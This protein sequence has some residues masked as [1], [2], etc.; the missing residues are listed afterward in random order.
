VSAAAVI[1]RRRKTFIRRFAEMDATCPERAIAFAE[2]GMRRSWVFD[3]M[4]GRGV[5]V[6]VCGERFYMNEQ[7]AHAFLAAQRRRAW[8]I[9]AILLVIFIG[10][11][12]S[13]SL[14]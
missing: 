2:I 9:A 8:R 14:W 11:L 7:A 13:S 6:P 10:F 4:V 1:A 5:F 3:Q 12:I